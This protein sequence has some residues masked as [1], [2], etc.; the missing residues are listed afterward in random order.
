MTPLGALEKG[1]IVKLNTLSWGLACIA[2][3]LAGLVIAEHT[4]LTGMRVQRDQLTQ[5][6]SDRDAVR[7][8]A[9]KHDCGTRSANLFRTLGYSDNS[10]QKKDGLHTE[11]FANHFSK[12]LGRCLIEITIS[13]VGAS[14][15]QA[16]QTIGKNIYDADER[17][18][19]G[20]YYWIASNTKKYWEQK[21]F[22]CHMTP[23]DKDEGV[24]NSTAEWE[25]F[26]QELMSS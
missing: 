22:Q 15:G 8:E 25:K 14:N 5:K 10:A 21:P 16:R 7:L 4:E 1:H 24:C 17:R 18:S 12:R 23:P 9:A 6:L 19:F 26:E 3:V 11:E 13:D 20:D 2:V